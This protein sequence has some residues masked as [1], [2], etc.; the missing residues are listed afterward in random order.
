MHKM[1]RAILEVADAAAMPRRLVLGSA[2]YAHV[3][4]GLSAGLAELETRQ[5][6]ACAMDIDR[7]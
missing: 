3:H 1:V 6:L 4:A 2:A 5:A 7:P